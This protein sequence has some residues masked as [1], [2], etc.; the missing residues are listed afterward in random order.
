MK[1]WLAD[2]KVALAMG[3]AAVAAIAMVAY[4]FFR[5]AEPPEEPVAKRMFGPRARP[6]P[7]TRSRHLVSY[8]YAISGVTY[9]TA[10]DIT[11][12]EGQIRFERLV[13]G[14]PAS[15]KYDPA[16]PS[17]SIIVADDWSGLR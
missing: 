7:D 8:S 10:Q 1:T 16:N 4:A 17:D 13:T 2:W 5:P 14:Q 9:H 3:A 11:R 6:I 12:L 15:I